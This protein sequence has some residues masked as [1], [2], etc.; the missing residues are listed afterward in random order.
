VTADGPGSGP[1]PGVTA[2]AGDGVAGSAA[3]GTPI[4]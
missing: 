1:V 3:L 4:V 2:D